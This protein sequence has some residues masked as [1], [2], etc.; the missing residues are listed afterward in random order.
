M[1]ASVCKMLFVLEN[2]VAEM[3]VVTECKLRILCFYGRSC[4]MNKVIIK[5]D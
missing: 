4:V 5:P 1:I 2:E 3:A